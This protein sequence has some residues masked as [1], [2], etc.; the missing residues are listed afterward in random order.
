VVSTVLTRLPFDKVPHFCC[1]ISRRSFVGMVVKIDKRD[2]ICFE[3]TTFLVFPRASN[4]GNHKIKSHD[5]IFEYL[6]SFFKK[7]FVVW[8]ADIIFFCR[9]ATIANSYLFREIYYF[10]FFWYIFKNSFV[11]SVMRDHFPWF[12]EFFCAQCDSSITG[13]LSS[14]KPGHF[15][16]FLYFADFFIS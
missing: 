6:G 11:P 10:S 4:I 13:E 12:Y 14:Q 16:V 7:C 2:G 1:H 8:M 3:K 9:V 5:R 15:L